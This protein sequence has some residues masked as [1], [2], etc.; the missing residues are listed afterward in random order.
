MKKLFMCNF[1][2]MK[3]TIFLTFLFI[4][5]GGL[6]VIGLQTVNDVSAEKYLAQIHVEE[7]E[8]YPVTGP[9]TIDV[10]LRRSYLTGESSEEV[11]SETIV[12]MEDFWAKY[13]EWQLVDQNAEKIIFEKSVNDI[14]PLLKMNGHF[15]LSEEG[16]LTIY[17][18]KPNEQKVIQS[19]YQVDV[20]K[21]ES[22]LH[23]QL[24]TGI[25]VQTKQKFQII[26]E[27]FKQY[28]LES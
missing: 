14:S 3:G 19:F 20:E 2:G 24:R 8:A 4:I 25:P 7:E 27:G 26:I 5:I 13:Q 18:G 9:I 21:L 28:A 11:V 23:Q 1:G 22:H 15:G 17:D 10:H 16:I 12:S 6:Y